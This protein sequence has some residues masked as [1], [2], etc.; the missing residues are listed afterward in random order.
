MLESLELS[1]VVPKWSNNLAELFFQY[2]KVP[3]V[4][5]TKFQKLYRFGEQKIHGILDPEILKS[6]RFDSIEI[7]R[8]QALILSKWLEK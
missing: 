8:R 6:V 5:S 2:E 7:S 4:Y 3:Y 1:A